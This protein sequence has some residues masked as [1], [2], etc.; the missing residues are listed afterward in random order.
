MHKEDLA[1]NNLQWLIC[2]K[3]KQNLIASLKLI[4]ESW[5][6]KLKLHNFYVSHCWLFE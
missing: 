4:K 6:R 3:T 5:R 1:L 2:H